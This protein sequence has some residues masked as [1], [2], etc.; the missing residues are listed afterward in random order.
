M[1]RIAMKLSATAAAMLFATLSASPALAQDEAGDKVETAIVYGEDPCPESTES[2]IVICERREEEERYRIP[3]P[4]RNDPNSTANQSWSQRVQSF[5]YVG[6]FGTES[7]SPAGAGGFTGCTQQLLR[8]ARA[9]RSTRSEVQA[10]RLIEEAR[11]ERLS[12]IDE[13]A[14]EQQRRVEEAERAYQ[15]R[16]EERARQEAEQNGETLDTDADV[17]GEDLAVPPS[18]DDS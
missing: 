5:E 2:T 11:Q 7:C 8:K 12:T 15:A 18:G 17:T 4:L 14:A 16:E 10:G 6:D 1:T 9:E 13:E 3:S